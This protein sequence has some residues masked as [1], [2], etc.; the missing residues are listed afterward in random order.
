[1]YI[2]YASAY[3]S[4]MYQVYVYRRMRIYTFIRV[5]MLMPAV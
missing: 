2:T 1:M 4:P 3:Q 5:N